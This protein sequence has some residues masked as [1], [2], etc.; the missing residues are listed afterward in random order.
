M[1]DVRLRDFTVSRKRNRYYDDL[2][3]SIQL[4]NGDHMYI[5]LMIKKV[6]KEGKDEK[7][8]MCSDACD[9]FLHLHALF[10]KSRN[11]VDRRDIVQAHDCV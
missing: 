1:I 5:P 9:M 3:I 7:D 8:G 2:K 11:V 4:K 10:S 6:V